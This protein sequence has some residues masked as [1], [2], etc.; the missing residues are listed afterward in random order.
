MIGTTSQLGRTMSRRKTEKSPRPRVTTNVDPGILR[1]AK[2]VA[3]D[4]RVEMFDYLD[5]ILRPVIERDYDKFIKDESGGKRP[6][7]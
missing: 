5:S 4:R 2:I 1:K 3:T 7:P 6:T